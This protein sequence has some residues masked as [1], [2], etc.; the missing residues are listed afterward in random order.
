MVKLY[1]FM[2]GQGPKTLKGI[3]ILLGDME[4]IEDKKKEIAEKWVEDCLDDPDSLPPS[5]S[6]WV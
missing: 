3:E 2:E 6:E 1:A 4:T 5:L